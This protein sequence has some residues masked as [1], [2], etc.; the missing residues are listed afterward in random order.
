MGR[1]GR[2]NTGDCADGRIGRV[3]TQ[4]CN[5]SWDHPKLGSWKEGLWLFGKKG[6]AIEGVRKHQQLQKN[7]PQKIKEK[8]LARLKKNYVFV[9]VLQIWVRC[10]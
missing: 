1:Q 10:H 7:L 2:K 4:G 3:P 5:L 8:S 9:R 6:I